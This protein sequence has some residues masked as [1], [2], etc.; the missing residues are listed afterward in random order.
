MRPQAKV[1]LMSG[2]PDEA[3]SAS[4]VGDAAVPF[5]A[6]PFEKHQLAAAVRN[7]LDR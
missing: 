3:M 6:K 4:T 5:L 2:Y 7:V 1:L